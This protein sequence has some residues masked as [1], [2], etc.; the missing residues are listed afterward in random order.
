MI[1]RKRNVAAILIAVIV[2]L[3]YVTGIPGAL[4]VDIDV[5]DVDPVSIT[6]FINILIAMAVGLA[7]V[8]ILIPTFEVG[9]TSRN[10]VS[11]LRAFGISCVIAF[12]VPF[13]AVIIGLYPFD[14]SPT[15]WKVLFEGVIY[16][17]GVGIIEEF[18]C[19]GL[20]QNGIA[21]LL[22]TRKNS[23]LVAIL[24]T[25]TVFGLGH[26]VAVI[27]EPGWPAFS[28]ILWAIGLGVYFGAIYALTK[29]L[30]LVAMFHFVVN[31][32]GLPFNFSSQDS[33]PAVSTIIVLATYL[34]LAM[35]GIYVL[36]Q[37]DEA[38]ANLKWSDV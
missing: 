11:G 9:F 27:G 25:A 35:Y 36:R 7:L 37:R 28:R 8:R 20:L 6:L 12:L 3:M 4:F 30:W 13:V 2:A 1:E 31:L 33:Y 21:G 26:I 16:F 23:Q 15:I 34:G 38:P 14:H 19:R 17:I 5:G 24:I 10:F 32:S 18:F 29:N 22:D